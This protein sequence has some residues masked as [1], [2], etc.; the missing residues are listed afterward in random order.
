[1][2]GNGGHNVGKHDAKWKAK[3]ARQ[4]LRVGEGFDLSAVDPASTPGFGGKKEDGER[5]LARDAQHLSDLQEMFFAGSRHGDT[6]TVLL[7]LQGMDT[8]GKGGVVRHVVGAIDPQGVELTAFKAPT[9][10][11]LSH[12]F[13]WRVRG[14][15]PGAGMI[16]VFDR[17]HYE[18]V[19][20]GRVQQLAPADEIE[21]R[22][23]LINDF[24][25]DV[26]GDDT[27][28]IKVMLHIS[29]E[30]QRE[31]LRKRLD[32]PDKYWKFDPG[33]ID[34][35]MR[36][37]DYLEAYQAALTR[38]STEHAPWFV[39]PADHKWYA[40]LAVQHLLLHALSGMDLAWPPADFDIET[41]KQ[42]LADS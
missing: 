4:A 22:Y 14:R 36:W 19:L 3:E 11:E 2:A 28:I 29:K 10:A 21:H 38:T 18:D 33:D 39:V 13:L 40:R 32:R 27:T 41:Q 17:S 5:A 6:R 37:D 12:G 7:V 42:R 24:E 16:G 23:D 25:R 34:Q 31:R 26:A 20:I 8:S 1:M 9:K 30:E 35:R 15:L